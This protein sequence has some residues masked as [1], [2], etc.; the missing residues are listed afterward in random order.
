MYS[1]VLAVHNILRWVAIIL[2]IVA[3]ARAYSGWLG[4][5]EWTATDRKIGVFF[6][7]AMDLQLLL[8]LILYI[9]LSPTTR[10]AFSNFGAAM[11]VADVRFFA[12]EHILYMVIAIVCVHIGTA[13]ARK[14]T[15]AVD[16]HRQAAIWFSLGGLALLLGMPWFRP[17][18]PGLG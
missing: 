2:A 7:S 8:G 5:R 14:A 13:A 15:Q 9:V 11:R 18:L 12:L 10:T 17:W 16:K 1:F 3:L 6:A 4:R